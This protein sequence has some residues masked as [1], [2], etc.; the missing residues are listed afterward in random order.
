MK[1]KKPP[2]WIS[3]RGVGRRNGAPAP[4]ILDPEDGKDVVQRRHPEWAEHEIGWRRLMDSLEGGDR[5]RDAV[6]GYDRMGLPCR[7]LFRH[8]REYPD[9]KRNPEQTGGGYPGAPNVLVGEGGALA[10]QMGPFPGMLGA[11]PA[12]IAGDDIYELRRART[13]V[14]EWV[15]DASGTHL[16]KIYDQEIFRDPDS[17]PPDL[18]EWW[19]DVDGSGTTIDDYFKDTVA[20]LLTALGTLDICMDRPPAPPG[21]EIKSREDEIRFGLDQVV[22]SYILPMNVVWWSN[23]HAGR[24]IEVLVR[25]YVDP[26]ERM[27]HDSN[28]NAIDPEGKGKAADK[29][30]QD[31]VRFRLWRSGE[32]ILY[33]FGGDAILE[34]KPHGAGRVPIVRLQALKKHRSKMVGK[35]F[36]EAVCNLARAYYN[37]DSELILS[38]VLQATPLLA[39]PEKLLKGDSTVSVGPEFCLPMVYDQEK[40]GFTAPVYVSPPQ[41]PADS[42]RKDKEDFRAAADR[43]ACLAKP[44]GADRAGTIAQSG[45]SKEIDSRT[46]QKLLRAISLCLAKAETF[47]A[48]LALVVMRGGD[49]TPEET[50]SIVVG[51]PTEYDIADITSLMD[52]TT[53]FQLIL[54]AAGKA[55]ETEATIIQKMVRQ[56]LLGMDDDEYEAMDAEIELLVQTQATL[57]EGIHELRAAMVKDA[58]SQ[59]GR[60]GDINEDDPSGQSGGTSLGATTLASV[61]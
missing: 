36:Y 16:A 23:D 40:G 50:A 29:W 42:L 31:Y 18:I 32:S 54:G 17:C 5:F 19:K 45:L 35:S 21:V 52:N 14:P 6:Y 33:N 20:P 7:M 1:T 11:D 59:R 28:G 30:R 38:N 44:P 58:S 8:E 34:R 22:A 46:G 25:E 48:E 9:P 60:G 43:A 15:G 41:D 24:Y 57:K 37:L 61:S 51:Y 53:K 49:L 13:P 27:D 2:R 10:L 56:L 3:G 39:I 4:G 26:S 55:P 47:V 12:S